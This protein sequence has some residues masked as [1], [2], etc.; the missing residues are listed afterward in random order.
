[1]SA[2]LCSKEAWSWSGRQPGGTG[3]VPAA[4]LDAQLA[5]LV[6]PED[7]P[8]AAGAHDEA[9]EQQDGDGAAHA[10]GAD[11]VAVLQQAAATSLHGDGTAAAAHG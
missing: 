11:D 6:K 4:H 10:H 8:G 7:E 3:S 5:A 1:M 9:N 2:W